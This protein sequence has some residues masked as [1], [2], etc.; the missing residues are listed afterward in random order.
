MKALRLEPELQRRECVGGETLRMH[1]VWALRTCGPPL[2]ACAR[3]CV[4]A[5][6]V[7]STGPGRRKLYGSCA[8]T[9]ADSRVQ[10]PPQRKVLRVHAGVVTSSRSTTGAYATTWLTAKKTKQNIKEFIRV[11]L[12]APA[13]AP[14]SVPAQ[15]WWS[16]MTSSIMTQRH[17]RG[18]RSR[19][20]GGGGAQKLDETGAKA[21]RHHAVNTLVCSN[22]T[23]RRSKS[24]LIAF[25]CVL[26]RGF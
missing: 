25:G 3:S 2:R 22:G 10:F 5:S 13:P 4:R 7:W 11:R 26:T 16:L 12:S 19:R 9:D 18:F 21:V 8:I 6:A 24:C 17:L 23:H 14:Q 1:T 15:R 20:S